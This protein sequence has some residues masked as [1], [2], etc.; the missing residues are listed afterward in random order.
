MENQW[1]P[2]RLKQS[3]HVHAVYCHIG[4]KTMLGKIVRV[5]VTDPQNP[6]MWPC[7]PEHVYAVHPEDAEK[8]LN[9]DGLMTITLCGCQILAD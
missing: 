6:D 8:I 7:H 4:D 9:Y 2:V 1:Q 3:G 5:R